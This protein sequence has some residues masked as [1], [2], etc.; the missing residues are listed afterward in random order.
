MN[1][2][3][4]YLE[5]K[6]DKLLSEH[7]QSDDIGSFTAAILLLGGLVLITIVLLYIRD[8][9]TVRMIVFLSTLLLMFLIYK[10]R[11]KSEGEQVAAKKLAL[12]SQDI[13]VRAKAKIE[14]LSAGLSLKKTRVGAAKWFYSIVFP[15]FLY[16]VKHFIYSD[17]TNEFVL[18]SG[19]IVFPLSYL[20]WSNFYSGDKRKLEADI[21]ELSRMRKEL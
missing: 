8:G 16:S 14:Y 19:L 6:C 9:F 17:V 15:L 7:K 4:E 1:E 18:K 3:I 5:S 2:E 11:I 10:F 12:D 13:I 21:D 20:I